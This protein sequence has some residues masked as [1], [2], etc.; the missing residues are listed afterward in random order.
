MIIGANRI[1][2]SYIIC[3]KNVPDLTTKSTLEVKANL[4]ARNDG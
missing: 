4:G 2:L 3:K 1:A